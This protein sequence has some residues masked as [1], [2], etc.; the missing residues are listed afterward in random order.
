MKPILTAGMPK[1]QGDR[2]YTQRENFIVET[3]IETFQI[4]REIR[5]ESIKCF[6]IRDD[7][8]VVCSAGI[9]V[10]DL[11]SGVVKNVVSLS[12]AEICAVF[13]DE[14]ETSNKEPKAFCVV[15]G[16]AD[17]TVS[18]IDLVSGTAVW[19]YMMNSI[20]TRL[21]KIGGA[22][23][24]A[25]SGELWIY[26]GGD[27]L[28]KHQEAEI[29]GIAYDGRDACTVSRNGVLTIWGKPWK[30]I[31][32]GMECDFMTGDGQFLYACKGR[33]IY[34]Y[35]YGGKL[36]ER[37]ELLSSEGEAVSGGPV[38]QDASFEDES[39]GN[40]EAASGKEGA[41]DHGGSS[42][43]CYEDESG[44]DDGLKRKKQ[45]IDMR[46]IELH[47]D[48]EIDDG[49]SIE[50]MSR[51][52]IL[53]NEQEI[54]LID[55]DLKVVSAIIGNND[56]VT[57]MA[58]W[59]DVLLVATNSGRLRYTIADDSVGDYA[60]RGWPIL[61]HDEVIMSLSI[62]GDFLMTVS[63]DK[64]AVLW[65]L[66]LKETG[67]GEE[68]ELSLRRVK[69]LENSLSGLNGCVLGES[70][71][72]IVG[73]DQ[74]LQ[75]WDYKDSV[76]MER[77]HDKE[78]NSVEINEQRRLIVT[79]SQDRK[80]KI[81][82]FEGRVL[83][84]L[85]GHT[86]GVWSAAFGKS[87][88]ATCS[89][90]TSIKVWT[91][92]TFE[93][94]GTLSGHRSAVLRGQFYKGDEKFISGCATGEVKIWNVKKRICEMSLDVHKDRVWTLIGGPGLTTSG[95]GVIA[96][97]EDDTLEVARKEIERKNER[98]AQSIEVERCLRHNLHVKAVEILSKTEDHRLLFKTLVRC[99]R[100]RPGEV[101]DIFEDKQKMFFDAIL[102]QGTFKNCAVVQWLVEEGLRRKWKMSHEVADKI[103]KIVEKHSSSI[104]G[105]YSTLL[106]FAALER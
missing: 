11:G 66:G 88:M 56:E 52:L 68:K 22:V 17:G 21:T 8:M 54:F 61:A 49:M 38:K 14:L 4:L 44:T 86:K 57:D 10:Y 83:H 90:D 72:V 3:D 34:I 87:L 67:R 71:F 96:F 31:S 92:E 16:R 12:K 58:R 84:V 53:T 85:S 1:R 6:D 7:Y 70:I 37:R 78:I 77:I 19:S 25:D 32:L 20:V 51:D 13:I 60:F 48:V 27:N 24:S 41:G 29:V 79:C 26:N 65:K 45:A 98:E 59:G 69:T 55:E 95:N 81:L 40:S 46:S 91:M 99:Y 101:F 74:I 103:Y 39:E 15:V 94:V 28:V 43:D 100:E 76:F 33:S 102:K 105:I 18:K 104:D 36:R 23:C 106:G 82:S 89:A 2:L 35:D 30:K 63:R 9:T 64:R 75:I 42:N 93:C 5:F 62:H 73:C 47:E 80:A 50:G 97:F